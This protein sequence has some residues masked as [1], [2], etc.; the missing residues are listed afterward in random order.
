MSFTVYKQEI[1]NFYNARRNYDNDTTRNRAIAVFEHT[2]LTPGQLVLDVATGTGIIA[3]KA[4][5]QVGANGSVIGIDIAVE[6]LKLSLAKSKFIHGNSEVIYHWKKLKISG[7]VSFGYIL[8][9]RC[10][11]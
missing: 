11:N 7:M 10:G 1:I 8:I 4:A 5:K 9:I 6:L 2:T 3:I